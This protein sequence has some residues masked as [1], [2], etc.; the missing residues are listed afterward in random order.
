MDDRLDF[1][2]P[3][4]SSCE[5]GDGE[6]GRHTLRGMS[7]DGKLKGRGSNTLGCCFYWTFPS[8][9]VVTETPR[10]RIY[11]GLPAPLTAEAKSL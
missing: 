6:G 3:F 9:A 7:N 5:F 8:G 11:D 2:E 10:S 1:L 4:F